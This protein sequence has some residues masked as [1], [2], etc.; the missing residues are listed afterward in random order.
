MRDHRRLEVFLLADEL[1]VKVYR[2]TREMPQSERYGLTS[3]MRRAA[4][5]VPTN[6][7]EGC[8]RRTEV[9][10]DRFLSIAFGSVESDHAD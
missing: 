6:I 10:F 1:A 4:V 3:Q 9:E 8:G 7:V 5:S 2:E